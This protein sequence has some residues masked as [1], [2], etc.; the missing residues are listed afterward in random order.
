MSK[1]KGESKEERKRRKQEK[2]EKKKEKRKRSRPSTES[3]VAQ[4]KRVKKEVAV[5]EDSIFAGLLGGSSSA[6]RSGS[7]AATD[8]PFQTKK[9]NILVS[10]CPSSLSN[11]RKAM[12]ASIQKLLL[13][14]SDSLG[15]VLLSFDNIQLD[16]GTSGKR[17]GGGDSSGRI[18]N[19]MPHI[20]FNVSCNVLVFNP[21]IGQKLEGVVNESFPS[22]VGLLV[23]ELFNAMVSADYLQA[24]GFQFD[25]DLNEWKYEKTNNAIAVGD[26]MKITVN[27]MHE[28]NGLISMECKD[29]TLVDESTTAATTS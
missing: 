11:I 28:S 21:S 25:A 12:H 23:Y 19:E 24:N 8:S 14:Y 4:D 26:A 7:S 10:L 1:P 6:S 15:G 9:A 29:A 17:K 2:K 22:H 16:D 3:A 20:H 5:E 13:K 18:I 27:K